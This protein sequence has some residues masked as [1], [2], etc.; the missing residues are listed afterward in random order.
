MSGYA[1]CAAALLAGGLLPAMALASKGDAID[2]LVGLEIVSAVAVV[3]MLLIA[4]VAGE[5]YELIVPL[6]L[7]PLSVAGTLVFTRLLERPEDVS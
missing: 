1:I 6:V 3:A 4:Q 5:S 2:R 7:V